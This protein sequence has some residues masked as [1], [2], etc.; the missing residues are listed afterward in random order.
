MLDKII[1]F[2]VNNTS[3]K[4]VIKNAYTLLMTFMNGGDD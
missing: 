1:Q 4:I 2:S 3:S